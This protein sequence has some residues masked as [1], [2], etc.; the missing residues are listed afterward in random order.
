M[1]KSFLIFALLL[2]M[3]TVFAQTPEQ[4]LY[5]TLRNAGLESLQNRKYA[6]ALRQLEGA[7]GIVNSDEIHR[8]IKR[9]NDSINAAFNRAKNT[10]YTKGDVAKQ[11]A[12]VMFSELQGVRIESLA[13]IGE[14]YYFM[15][16]TILAREYFEKGIAQKDALSAYWYAS[17]LRK[18]EFKNSTSR[19][20]VLYKMATSFTG[21]NDS[22]GI[23]Y[24]RLNINDSAYYWYG[25]SNSA[26]SKYN[27]ACLLLNP[28]NASVMA[29]VSDNPIKLLE[30]VATDP[31]NDKI[32]R[33]QAAYYLGML[34]RYNSRVKDD[35][36]NTI[37][38]QWIERAANLGHST[39]KSIL[40]DKNLYEK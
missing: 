28:A 7:Q 11:R 17:M 4:D 23:E 13:Y 33:A 3:A 24:E 16:N 1:K 34:Y 12:I 35:K 26:Y 10:F 25:K 14:S 8:D 5:R 30:D 22:I 6:D 27:R 31:S 29:G 32:I 20:I 21:V 38:W 40:R 36:N 15:G 19:R 39:A 18:I 9:V 37:G 2:S